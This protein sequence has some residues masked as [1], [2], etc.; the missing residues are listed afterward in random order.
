VQI[1]IK[2]HGIAALVRDLLDNAD[3]TSTLAA[4]AAAIA[5]SYGLFKIGRGIARIDRVVRKKIANT[6]AVRSATAFVSAEPD[7]VDTAPLLVQHWR[8]MHDFASGNL[9]LAGDARRS[10]DEAGTLLDALD[11]EI[12][13]LL[14]E[15]APVS[16]YAAG[17]TGQTAVAPARLG[18]PRRTSRRQLAA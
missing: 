17:R 16:T 2:G 18:Q 1:E 11:F 12:A 13:N 8:K 3:V 5:L 7:R 15:L 4:G 6:P 10:H 14:T 9:R